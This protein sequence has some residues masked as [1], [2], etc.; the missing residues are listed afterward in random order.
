MIK[1]LKSLIYGH[2]SKESK[3]IKV[4]NEIGEPERLKKHCLKCGKKK[5]YEGYVQR[6]FTG[7]P[8]PYIFKT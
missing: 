2:E 8:E 7:R 1:K 5:I 6:D 4:F 3:T